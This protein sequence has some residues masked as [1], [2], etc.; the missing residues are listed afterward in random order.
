M[1]DQIPV[2]RCPYCG[3]EDIGM[4][5]QHDEAMVTYKKHGIFGNR[6]RLYICRRCGSVV[7][8]CVAKPWKF[9][10]VSGGR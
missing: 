7:Y 3:C 8:Q 2:R 4:G 6:L 9:P 1:E 10:S 5:W